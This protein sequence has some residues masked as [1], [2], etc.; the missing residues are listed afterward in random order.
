LA[1]EADVFHGGF[2][3]IARAADGAHFYFGGS[4][5]M[6]EAALEFDACLGG[7]L[8]AEATEIR[9]N[10]SFYHPHAFGVSL[11]ARHANAPCP[12]PA[13]SRPASPGSPSR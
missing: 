13:D 1:D 3:A 4:K 5:E 11:S 7:V 2:G 6:F 9:A 8:H 12:Y 10:A